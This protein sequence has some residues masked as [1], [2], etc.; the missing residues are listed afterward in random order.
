N[1]VA[2]DADA[3]DLDFYDVSVFHPDRRFAECTDTT[4][5]ASQNHI[6]RFELC[7]GGAVL[8][9]CRYIKHEVIKRSAL[10]LCAIQSCC[11]LVFAKVAE[12]VRCDQPWSETAGARE[13]LAWCELDSVALKIANRA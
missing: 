10:H 7:E 3:F 8:N 9:K 4:C 5:G 2:Q 12:F 13:V 1:G 11:D 6:A